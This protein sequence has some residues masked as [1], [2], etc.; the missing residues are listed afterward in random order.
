[1]IEL[2]KSKCNVACITLSVEIEDLKDLVDNFA[3]I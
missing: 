2:I 1:V 3:E